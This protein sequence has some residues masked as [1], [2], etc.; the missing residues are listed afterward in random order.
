[1]R[2]QAKK[3]LIALLLMLAA[4]LMSLLPMGNM[5]VSAE[6]GAPQYGYLNPGDFS[7]ELNQEFLNR[8]TG[9]NLTVLSNDAPAI[10]VLTHGLNSDSSHWSN[11]GEENKKF[12][13]N[14]NSLL[15]KLRI[16]A[17]DAN[18]YH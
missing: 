16:A 7:E 2:A 17:N 14:T 1:M 6:E 13:Y 8:H 18:M 12:R 5:R 10:T 3:R 9:T 15:E 4:V 11:D